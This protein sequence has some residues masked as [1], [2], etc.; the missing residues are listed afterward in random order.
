MTRAGACGTGTATC[1]F[2]VDAARPIMPAA[3]VPRKPRRDMQQGQ[4]E[5]RRTFM[6]D[7]KA[8]QRRRG[9][10]GSGAA[11]GSDQASQA[12]LR[13][14]VLSTFALTRIVEQRPFQGARGEEIRCAV[15]PC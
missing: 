8:S 12:P 2:V 3:I 6:V 13:G 15:K 11:A 14:R 9:R 7:M 10:P 5:M 1:A 4:P